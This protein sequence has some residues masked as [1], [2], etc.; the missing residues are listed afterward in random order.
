MLIRNLSSV[1]EILDLKDR[2][3]EIYYNGKLLPEDFNK[4]FRDTLIDYAALSFI[5][6]LY[7]LS[8]TSLISIKEWNNNDKKD[9]PASPNFDTIYTYLPSIA[10]QF[11]WDLRTLEKNKDFSESIRKI[12]L[13]IKLMSMA[14][15]TCISF[16]KVGIELIENLDIFNDIIEKIEGYIT[17]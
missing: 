14:V 12:N 13:A 9:V 16:E 2:K 17:P 1:R 4:E 3:E 8:I 10:Y 11:A 15:P 6:K 5:K 7:S